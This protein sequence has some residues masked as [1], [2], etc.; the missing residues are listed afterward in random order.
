MMIPPLFSP[1]MSV[2]LF[3]SAE[4]SIKN[5]MT[6]HQTRKDEAKIVCQGTKWMICWN[7]LG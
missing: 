4:E 3:A 7:F 2:V 1:T 6:K 5:S